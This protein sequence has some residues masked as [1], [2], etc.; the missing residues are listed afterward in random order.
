MAITELHH[1]AIL[2]CF[3][4]IGWLLGLVRPARDMMVRAITPEGNA[5]KVFGFMS[6]GHLVGGVIVPVLYGWIIDQGEVRW[7][8][9]ITAL[10]MVIAMLT[11][12]SPARTNNAPTSK[13]G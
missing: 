12:F 7:I 6:T 11:L 10:L 3:A 8:F 4:I 2:C 13:K 9:W 1:I 5:G